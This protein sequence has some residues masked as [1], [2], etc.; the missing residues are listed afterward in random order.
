[1]SSVPSISALDS[2][3]L[4][5]WSSQVISGWLGS[6]ASGGRLLPLAGQVY[7][8]NLDRD[9]V[10]G[11]SCHFSGSSIEAPPAGAVAAGVAGGVALPVGVALGDF[12]AWRLRR[13]A[14]PGRPRAAWAS[15]CRS[16]TLAPGVVLDVARG[17][18]AGRPLGDGGRRR[19]SGTRLAGLRGSRRTSRNRSWAVRLTES[20]RSWRFLPGISTTMFLPPW[21]LTSDSETPLPL[22]R[23]SMM[24]AA[25]ASWD[26]RRRLR[27]GQRDPGAA[28]EVEA[29]A[30]APVLAEGRSAVQQG[31][32]IM[33]MISVRPARG[34]FF[35]TVWCSSR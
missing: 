4:L 31:H 27:R 34:V 2:R 18:L 15:R 8:A 10:S 23:S 1:M 28:L 3:N 33:K 11:L 5:P 35:A 9:A 6:S 14:R 29:Q 17:E 19:A 16:P 20:I 24:F 32:P 13:P 26:W 21:V 7:V 12:L 30:R 22:T 25:R